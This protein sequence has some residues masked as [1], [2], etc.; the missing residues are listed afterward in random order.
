[1]QCAIDKNLNRSDV[2]L[3]V[4]HGK[5]QDSEYPPGEMQGDW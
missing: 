5:K 2:D 3:R 1:M 4:E